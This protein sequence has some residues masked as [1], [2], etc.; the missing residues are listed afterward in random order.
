[1]PVVT[2]RLGG[3]A[4]IVDA[5]CGICVSPNDPEQLADAL[6]GLIEDPMLRAQ[7]GRTGRAR[8]AQLC[9]PTA[10]LSQLATILAR[11]AQTTTPDDQHGEAMLTAGV[12][13]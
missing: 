11:F 5:S 3:A 9:D 1:L 12:A 8:A 4:E 2:A 10:R 13:R 6:R 7:L